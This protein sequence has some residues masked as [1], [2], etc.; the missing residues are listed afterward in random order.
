MNVVIT[1]S[2]NKLKKYD[3]RID[4]RKTISFGAKGMSDFTIH[5]DEEIGRAHV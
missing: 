3:A 1:P 2:K 4:D 5:K